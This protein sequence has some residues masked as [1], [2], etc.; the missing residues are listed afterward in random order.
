M[1]WFS[2]NDTMEKAADISLGVPSL[3]ALLNPPTLRPSLTLRPPPPRCCR[4][5]ALAVCG[6]LDGGREGGRVGGREGERDSGPKHQFI[7]TY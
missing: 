7:S 4:N 2:A 1:S 5:A 3:S 6:P